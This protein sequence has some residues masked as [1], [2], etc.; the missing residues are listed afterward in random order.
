[1]TVCNNKIRTILLHRG[2]R[3]FQAA[4]CTFDCS[5]F[6][7]AFL[8]IC[9]L[10]TISAGWESRFLP[11][12]WGSLNVLNLMLDEFRSFVCACTPSPG[13]EIHTAQAESTGFKV[14]TSSRVA[15]LNGQLKDFATRPCY[16]TL[17]AGPCWWTPKAKVQL[18]WGTF[19]ES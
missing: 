13:C 3:S 4:T 18:C 15:E 6:K 5:N 7:F 16:W 11:S 8:S 12:F 1:M 19:K 2:M 17:Y 9:A 10:S 14:C